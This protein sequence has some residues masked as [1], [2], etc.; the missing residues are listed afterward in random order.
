MDRVVSYNLPMVGGVALRHLGGG[1]H[2]CC[3]FRDELDRRNIVSD[4][5]AAGIAT[6]DR[7]F[8]FTR[9]GDPERAAH[10]F[11]LAAFERL[12]ASGQ[13][14]VASAEDA[15]FE[16]GVFDGEARAAGFG[17]LA[18]AAV[19][20]GFR[21]VRVYADNGWMPATLDDPNEWIEY[22]LR[23]AQLVPK[24]PVIG[25]CGFLDRDSVVLDDEIIDAVHEH[26]LGAGERPSP[27]SLFGR[28]DGTWAVRGEI[29]L[30]CWESFGRVLASA[31][32]LSDVPTVDLSNLEF[33]DVRTTSELHELARTERVVLRSPSRAFVRL[34][35]LLGFDDTLLVG[36]T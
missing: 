20:E 6:G 23:I 31:G 29:D 22:E 16:D 32:A 35:G 26:R 36:T 14:T 21:R 33:I 10:D 18:D 24:H 28:A 8:V 15:Y 4:Y 34:W 12:T 11:G 25:L 5:L 3:T 27:Y 2:A 13:L 17:A 30:R 1:A 9:G 7:V 19:A